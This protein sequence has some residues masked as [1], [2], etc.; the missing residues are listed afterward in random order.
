MSIYEMPNGN[1]G[2]SAEGE[3]KRLG[4][5]KKRMAERKISLAKE[6]IERGERLAFPGI[7]PDSLRV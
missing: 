2:G 4:L 3:E 5:E 7:N 6:L 1:A